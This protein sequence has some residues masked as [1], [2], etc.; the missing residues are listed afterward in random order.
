MDVS[1]IGNMPD[2]ISRIVGILLDDKEM[3]EEK[4][5]MVYSTG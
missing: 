1:I 2:K 4:G 3:G 5:N